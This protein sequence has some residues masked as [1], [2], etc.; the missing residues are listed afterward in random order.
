MVVR[1]LAR[2]A[3][4]LREDL[5]L[6]PFAERREKSFDEKRAIARDDVWG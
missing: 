5:A 6:A 3:I 2:E 4:E 1:D